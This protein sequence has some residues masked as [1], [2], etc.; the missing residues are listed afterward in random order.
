[1]LG[2]SFTL[3][4]NRGRGARLTLSLPLEDPAGQDNSASEKA[5]A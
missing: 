2:G 4:S 1:M 3:D 5:H